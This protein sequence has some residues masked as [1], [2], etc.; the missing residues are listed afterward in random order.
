MQY[1]LYAKPLGET[2]QTDYPCRGKPSGNDGE[3][4]WS[5]GLGI[6]RL[7]ANEMFHRPTQNHRGTKYQCNPR[8]GIVTHLLR[9]TGLGNI[10]Y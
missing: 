6:V 9:I 3:P 4:V 1:P 5:E 8:L 10:I 2:I 7:V